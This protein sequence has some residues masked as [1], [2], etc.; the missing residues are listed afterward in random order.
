M[1]YFKKKTFTS[2]KGCFS[3]F[4]TQKPKKDRNSTK[5]RKMPFLK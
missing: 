3:N 4:A 1:T 2:Q 5:E